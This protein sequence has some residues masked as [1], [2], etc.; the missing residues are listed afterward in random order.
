MVART[1]ASGVGPLWPSVIEN[2]RCEFL[3]LVR[4]PAF[5]IPVIVFPLMFYGLF[6]LPW[7]H[8]VIEGVN[9]GDYEV[10]SFAAYGVI[11]VA[12][13]AFGVTVANDRGS[14]TTLLMRATPMSPIAYLGGKVLA[15]LLF[16]LITVLA[17]LI[18]AKITGGTTFQPLLWLTLTARLLAGVFPFITLGFAVGYLAGPN[19]A[20]A[21]LQLIN[22]PMSFAS[23]LFVPLDELPSFVRAIAPFL[24]AYHLGQLAWG[25]IGAPVEPAWTS[26]AWL[27]GFTVLF[28]TIALRAYYR[29]ET[30][31]FG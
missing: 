18:F 4:V 19:S 5:S 1:E 27:A 31:T 8:R 13:F 2:A 24:P 29:E 21:I 26:V 20:I 6:G 3:R 10:A 17:L 14:K 11:S 30:K 9:V 22:L 7:A 23:G 12:L 28:G 16:A 25:A 15:T